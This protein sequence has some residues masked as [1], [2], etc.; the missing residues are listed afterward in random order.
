MT[1]TTAL[2]AMSKPLNLN[3]DGECLKMNGN[4]TFIAGYNSTDGTRDWTLGSVSSTNKKLIFNNDKNDSTTIL[5]GKNA[6]NL[7]G[8]NDLNLHANGILL[9][10]GWVD[11]GNTQEYSGGI[12]Q[13]N[14]SLST[15]FIAG[16]GTNS[17]Y[18]DPGLGAITLNSNT[19][20]VSGQTPAGNGRYSNINMLNFAGNSWETQS[21]AFTETIKQQITTNTSDIATLKTRVDTL[22]TFGII[23]G[24]L[25]ALQFCGYTTPFTASTTYPLNATLVNLGLFSYYSGYTT[26]F[27]NVG[28]CILTNCYINIKF[29]CKFI[30]LNTGVRKLKS[31]LRQYN[32]GTSTYYS[33]WAGVDFNYNVVDHNELYHTVE[34]KFN[35]SEGTLFYLETESF[36]TTSG[37]GASTSIEGK[38]TMTRELY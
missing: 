35:V 31:R 3:V 34:M 10:R 15:F 28:A 2:T 26:F 20:W 6:S 1:S 7:K 38:I 37:D 8:R 22:S 19:I 18:I 27:N 29:E 16:N 30:C 24:Y 32:G 13:L 11:A 14:P 12:G 21:S 23:R 5:T 33:Y 4:Q 36:W 17:I 9:Y 25:S